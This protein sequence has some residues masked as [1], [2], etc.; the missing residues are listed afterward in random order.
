MK[1]N[2][3]NLLVLFA[4]AAHAA[5]SS[6]A[7]EGQFCNVKYMM[8]GNNFE[9]Y[10]SVGG[11]DGVDC[12][13]GLM[14]YP[15]PEY[16]GTATKGDVLPGT[17]NSTF[18]AGQGDPEYLSAGDIDP[19]NDATIRVTICH[20]TCSQTNPWVRITIDDDAWNGTH[21]SGCGHM[22]QHD[23]RDE[24]SK[25]AYNNWEAWGA[26]KKD[27]LI[28]WHGTRE[29]VRQVNGWAEPT[30][31]GNKW[32]YCEEE[33]D[34]WKLWERACPYVRNGHCCN[35]DDGSC[36]GDNP[37]LIPSIHLEKTAGP[38]GTCGIDMSKQVEV[39]LGTSGD[40]FE[41]CYEI[42]NNGQTCLEDMTLSDPLLNTPVATGTALS[43][44][45]S[46]YAV[47]YKLCPGEKIYISH[48]GPIPD[49]PE[50]PLDAIVEGKREGT[51]T[52]VESS[53]HA[54]VVPAGINV[55]KTAGPPGTCGNEAL[56]NQQVEVYGDALG[57]DFEWCYA[58]SNPSGTCLKAIEM[59]DTSAG[60]SGVSISLPA[61]TPA[62]MEILASPSFADLLCPGDVVYLKVPGKIPSGGSSGPGDVTGTPNVEGA[63]PV[64][65][66]DPASVVP[67]A[68]S[69][70]K[71][72]GPLGSCGVDM[73]LQVEAY[74]ANADS[75]FEYCYKI[76]I[77]AGGICVNSL[78]MSDSDIQS[79]FSGVAITSGTLGV[80][81]AP[82]NFVDKLCA[83]ESLYY[84]VPSTVPGPDGEAFEADVSGVGVVD[85]GNGPTVTDT[86]P[87]GV[88]PSTAPPQIELLKTA[89]PEG[90]CGVDMS[91]QVE[92][93][94]A[95]ED[96][97]FEYCY[98]VT[99][100]GLVCLKN[101]EMSDPSPTVV[102]S[103]VPVTG[104]SGGFVSGPD[105]FVSELCSG[106]SIYY[107]ATSTI[108][109]AAEGPIDAT[110][111]G[112]SVADGTPVDSS[113]GAGVK[114]KPPVPQ[115]DLE[116]TA[117]PVGSCGVDMSQQKETYV[118]PI[119]EAFEYCYKIS[120]PPGGVCVNNFMMSDTAGSV[121][122]QN[123]AVNSGNVDVVNA[124]AD[125]V[126]ELCAGGEI[127]FK[128]ESTIPGPNGEGPV[129]GK[130][131][132]TGPNGTPVSARN[133]AAVEPTLEIVLAKTSGPRGTCGID[134]SQQ[135]ETYQGPLGG[136][137]EYCYAI[138]N[139]GGV[140]LKNL[141]MSDP[142]ISTPYSNVP[143]TNLPADME[144]IVPAGLN[145]VSTL[146]A[147]ET[148][149]VSKD[150][151]I[152]GVEAEHAQVDAVSN[153][154]AEKP[155]SAVDHSGVE[156]VDD[157]IVAPTASPPV[158]PTPTGAPKPPDCEQEMPGKGSAHCGT[159]NGVE[160]I[161]V[162]GPEAT[163]FDADILWSISAAPDGSSVSFKVT[164]PFADSVDIY[165][166]YHKP[167]GTGGGWFEACD[168]EMA[169]PECGP[170][171][172]LI[173]ADCIDAEGAPFSVIQVYFVSSTPGFMGGAAVDECCHPGAPAPSGSVAQYTFLVSCTC[174]SEAR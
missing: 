145:F 21:A 97:G 40:A 133:P 56:M 51:S 122:F 10:T 113:N 96:T 84:T 171:A 164:S 55:E 88:A 1:F 16:E 135:V 82:S 130:V 137:F 163:A 22:L 73:T 117:G 123:E 115:L 166:Q 39:H 27:Y 131:D 41:Y 160:V 33:K 48:P 71:T 69:L 86:N 150:S 81:G 8:T 46:K 9:K 144:L 104:S 106:Q 44:L 63:P 12:A 30:K 126:D 77:P 50:G 87:A 94:E 107:K 154:P 11:Q 148:I 124:P 79:G 72:A 91:Q 140:C 20:R 83:G 65:D 110:V 114:P 103:S 149:Y 101:L 76:S 119:G 167:S 141:M 32:K 14:C 6:G 43:V 152:P 109:G 5:A 156:P 165:T 70:E 24:C 58:I 121:S 139:P 129:D 53:D 62:E 13:S 60:F 132:G 90:T 146:C 159:Y 2:I 19:T 92:V 138:T 68:I 28:K 25:Y 136:E 17:C 162:V 111:S 61:T 18:C 89:G 127:F 118:A 36:C 34:Y 85:G 100:T 153:T 59:T 128:K 158:D 173:T 95:D 134:M 93:Y 42:S 147:G 4:P 102:F 78:L 99:N 26:N 29:Y 52:V 112:V 54:A 108:P 125:F 49:G 143:I 105:G 161:S 151:T 57:A 31:T 174:P 37:N 75:A 80:S 142:D 23:V 38:Q 7:G 64:T 172:S 155:V 45:D 74:E 35:W 116:K 98:K 157:E 120:V 169:V 47:G 15:D 3:I 67:A 168:G 170:N 66:E